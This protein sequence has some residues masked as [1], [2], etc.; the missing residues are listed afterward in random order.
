MSGCSSGTAAC[1]TPRR[2]VADDRWARVGSTNLNIASWL[3]N[4]ELDVAIEDEGLVA[5]LAEMYEQDLAN[6][7]EIVLGKRYRVREVPEPD[8]GSNARRAFSGS[9][10]RAAAGAVSVGA[11]VRAALTSRRTLGPAEASLL[12]TAAAILIA[13]AAIA[14][15]WP[16][17][18]AYPIAL[19]AAW[20]G[21]VMLMRA[22]RLWRERRRRGEVPSS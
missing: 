7:T 10:G 21:I 12:G 15:M 14:V 1:S 8:K 19:I 6:A 3:A 11:V 13:F 17:V 4:Y 2:A 22:R 18:L 5:G 9:A 20:A 16:E